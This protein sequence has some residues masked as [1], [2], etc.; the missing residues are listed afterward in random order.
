MPFLPPRL[1]WFQTA[2]FKSFRPFDN[3]RRK[4]SRFRVRPEGTVLE[5]R[6]VP[7]TLDVN[8]LLA[9][10]GAADGLVPLREAIA[11]STN[12]TTTVLGQ[13]GTGN[14]TIVFD[15]SFAS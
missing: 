1:R 13:T 14:D 5:D 4:Q 6:L 11:A 3:V 9:P 2:V 8:S 15:A 7:A 12:H 10:P